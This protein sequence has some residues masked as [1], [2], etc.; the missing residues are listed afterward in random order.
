MD[1]ERTA[2]KK[3]F[4]EYGQTIGIELAQNG[5]EYMVHVGLTETVGISLAIDKRAYDFLKEQIKGID[6]TLSWYAERAGSVGNTPKER[7]NEFLGPVA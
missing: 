7:E 6:E 3:W 4:E 5:T 1:K 2:R